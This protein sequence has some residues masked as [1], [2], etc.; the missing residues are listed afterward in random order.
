MSGLNDRI[1]G[2][3]KQMAGIVMNDKRLETE[4]N[5][6]EAKG[7]VLE[8]TTQKLTSIHAKVDEM[9]SNANKK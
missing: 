7:H 8:K 3:A 1:R 9:K 4:G 2:R 5:A 6:Q